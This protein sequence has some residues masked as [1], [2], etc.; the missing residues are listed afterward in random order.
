MVS[1]E[2]N[3]RP[4]PPGLT[5]EF[6]GPDGFYRL[7]QAWWD[8]ESKRCHWTA[9]IHLPDHDVVLQSKVRQPEG[10]P[11][12]SEA[13]SAAKRE[14]VPEESLT[15]RD[16]GHATHGRLGL[17]GDPEDSDCACRDTLHEHAC[18]QE[19]CG[20]CLASHNRRRRP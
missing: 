18:A 7:I 8:T 4:T 12:L 6:T 15:P 3:T 17:E 20:F 11:T 1:S 13:L 14:P 19:G 5:E 16:E 9:R 10:F 2:R